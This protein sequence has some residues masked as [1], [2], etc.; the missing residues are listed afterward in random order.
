MSTFRKVH[1]SSFRTI[2]KSD[3]SESDHFHGF[4][5]SDRGEDIF[6]L[7]KKYSPSHITL[8]PPCI[9]FT[10]GFTVGITIGGSIRD[11]FT[12]FY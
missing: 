7:R 4:A 12:M 10:I 8:D 6:D 2:G 11:T 3:F 9:G 5:F 1:F